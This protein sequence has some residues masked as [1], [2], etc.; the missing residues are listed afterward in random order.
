MDQ[1]VLNAAKEGKGRRILENLGDPKYKGME[2]WQYS[3]ISESGSRSTVHYVRDPKT[4]QLMDFKF[5]VH[6]E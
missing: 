4:G 2:K 1:M 3:E 5:T 6:A